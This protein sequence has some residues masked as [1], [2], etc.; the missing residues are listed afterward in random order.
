MSSKGF[1]IVFDIFL[2]LLMSQ[3]QTFLVFTYIHVS[4]HFGYIPCC[5]LV[6]I[7]VYVLRIVAARKSSV[8]MKFW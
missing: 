2:S 7:A 6:K 1:R 4:I 5:Y 3:P 8:A